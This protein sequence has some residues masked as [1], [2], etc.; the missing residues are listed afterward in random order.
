MRYIITLCFL[1][2]ASCGFEPANHTVFDDKKT[3]ASR[4]V[5][6]P[7]SLPQAQNKS[8]FLLK[9][10]LQKKLVTTGGNYRLTWTYNTS[11][12]GQN[13]SINDNYQRFNK[14]YTL[15]WK[16]VGKQGNI[17]KS[18]AS[19]TNIGIDILKTGYPF[20]A[21]LQDAD[22]QAAKLLAEDVYNQLQIYFAK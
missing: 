15:N 11:F 13:L 20:E 14:S 8:E 19:R 9:T 2:L 3:G 4:S 16:L 1:L 12:V 22:R 21:S 17:L 5:V 10:E 18:F 7:I 6:P